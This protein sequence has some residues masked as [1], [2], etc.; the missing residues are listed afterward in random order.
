MMQHMA[1]PEVTTSPALREWQSTCQ[2]IGAGLHFL[3]IR[4]GGISEGSE[5]FTVDARRFA[6]LPT[7][8]HQA[9]DVPSPETVTISTVCDLVSAIVVP[10]DTDLRSLSGFHLYTREQLSARL[11][12]K[13]DQPVT[14]MAIRPWRLVNPVTVATNVV[15]PVCRSWVSV[16]VE[17]GELAEIQ[18]G[19]QLERLHAA[20]A[21]LEVSRVG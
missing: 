7:L 16:P 9:A 11:Q 15:R 5:G 17:I 10:G 4:K 8:F 14:L 13:P 6:L 19:G 20:L 3:L 21:A 1:G 12:Y 2:A 18:T